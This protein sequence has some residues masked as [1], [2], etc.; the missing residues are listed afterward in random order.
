MSHLDKTVEGIIKEAQ[1]RGEFDLNNNP[2]KGKP[3]E[4]STYFETP[5]HLRLA[6][7]ILKDSGYIPEEIDLKK[8]IGKLEEKLKRMLDTKERKKL[9]KEIELKTLKLNLIVESYKRKK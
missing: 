1:V 6:Y 9:R 7:K 4:L 3:L 8:E 5:E 2:K